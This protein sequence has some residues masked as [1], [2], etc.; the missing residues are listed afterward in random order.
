MDLLRLA[1]AP[2]LRRA[3]PLAQRA[4]RLARRLAGWFP[5]TPLGL[6]V[7]AGASAALFVYGQ[8]RQ[9]LVLW[10]VGA[11]G[12][13]L[14]ALGLLCT[15]LGTAALARRAGRARSADHLTAPCGAPTDTG[16]EL[17]FPAW[18]PFVETDWR[19][20]DPTVQTRLV[21]AGP[22]R[23]ER[24][25]PRR[26]GVR[27]AIRRRFQVRDVFG[28]T[29]VTFHRTEPRDAHFTPSTGALDR[30]HLVE[31]LAAGEDLGHPDGRPA[32]DLIDMRRYA[33]GDPIRH[34]LWKVYARTRALVV[35][36]PERAVS[37]ARRVVAY[38]VTGPDDEPA[39]GAARALVQSG[40]LGTDWVLAADGRP[41][42]ARTPE[43][44]LDLI[45]RSSET[46][47][48]AGAAGLVPFLEAAQRSG[49]LHAVVF[50]PPRPGPWLDRV[51]EAAAAAS[52]KAMTLQVV[53]GTDGV[54]ARDRRPWPL[55][56]A[57]RRAPALRPYA[58]GPPS[59]VEQ[60]ERV[61]DALGT[62]RARVQVVD[63]V[64]GRFHDPAAVVSE[65][66]AI[67]AHAAY[68]DPALEEDVA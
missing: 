21:P 63:R 35:R 13:G 42:H 32:G 23:A 6:L 58:P 45:T 8:G 16:F 44:A 17:A 59:P 1:P 53:V 9:D 19:W 2:L 12:L 54:E 18:L 65:A 36:T 49:A 43:Q 48:D 22:A 61:L 68:A 33:A 7:G 66:A 20:D 51:V 38:L 40:E 37:P 24:V 64:T 11:V 14:P 25:T 41:E 26:R 62:T 55:R 15:L 27:P 31:G 47:T 10:V 67:T 56:L 60:V 52:H 4:A 57:V 28:L 5:L 30:V 3:R 29:G 39:A 46:P 50:V 34:V